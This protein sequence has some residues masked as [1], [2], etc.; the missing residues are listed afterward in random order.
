MRLDQRLG[1]VFGHTLVAE[2]INV[3]REPKC[4][5]RWVDFSRRSFSTRV[6]AS[7]G[8]EEEYHAHHQR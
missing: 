2:K 3:L 4:Q 5:A 7:L 8:R 6:V 1:Y